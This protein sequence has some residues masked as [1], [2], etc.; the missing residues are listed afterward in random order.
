[1]KRREGKRFKVFEKASPGC[2]DAGRVK[3]QVLSSDLG[4]ESIFRKIVMRYAPELGGE[5]R[6]SAGDD[7]FFSFIWLILIL[8]IKRRSLNNKFFN[9]GSLIG[10][11]FVI[12]M[13][14]RDFKFHLKNNFGNITAF[15][16][17]RL[18]NFKFLIVTY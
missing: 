1:M 5:L 6:D 7:Q 11:I 17:R 8:N 16:A 12:F 10:S 18:L 13:N 15:T 2:M 9:T 14:V 3:N 4:R